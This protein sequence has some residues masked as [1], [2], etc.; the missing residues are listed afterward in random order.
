MKYTYFSQLWSCWH[1]LVAKT[2]K[3]ERGLSWCILRLE[4]C[5]LAFWGPLVLSQSCGMRRSRHRG[6]ARAGPLENWR[7]HSPRPKRTLWD[8][9]PSCTSYLSVSEYIS[10]CLLWTWEWWRFSSSS[11][12]LTW[13]SRTD[14]VYLWTKKMTV[15]MSNLKCV[16]QINNFSFFFFQFR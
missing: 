10:A 11:N 3:M 13:P 2:S 16:Y 9:C 7:T 8:S 1:R 12:S 5:V 4:P 6:S 14:W 15:T